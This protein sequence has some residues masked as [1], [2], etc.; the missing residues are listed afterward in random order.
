MTWQNIDRVLEA[1]GRNPIKGEPLPLK[2]RKEKKSK[3]N[4]W[5]LL[6]QMSSNNVVPNLR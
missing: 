1:T 4:S 2:K 6:H 3:G 5:Q